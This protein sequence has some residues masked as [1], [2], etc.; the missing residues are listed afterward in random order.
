MTRYE[1][2]VEE[3]GE[4]SAKIKRAI[5]C[6]DV[7]G[8]CDEIDIELCREHDDGGCVECWNKEFDEEAYRAYLELHSDSDCANG[9]CDIK[10]DKE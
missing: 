2:L 8:Y 6:P 10:F 7:Y 1:K 9:C 4:D 5:N 3:F